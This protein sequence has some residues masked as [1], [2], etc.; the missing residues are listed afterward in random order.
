[1]CVICDVP[2][3]SLNKWLRIYCNKCPNL[4]IIPTFKN[5]TNLHISSC[6]NLVI[7]NDQPK[8]K[9]LTLIN[10]PKLTSLPNLPNLTG[11]EIFDC[12]LITSFPIY[13]KIKSLYISNISLTTLPT[14]DTLNVLECELMSQL[15]SLPLYPNI[16]YKVWKMLQIN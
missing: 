4:T 12:V 6:E 10:A 15:V 3:K 5:L 16:G 2:F 8:V 1:M 7:F 9:L 13:P 14:S 11:L